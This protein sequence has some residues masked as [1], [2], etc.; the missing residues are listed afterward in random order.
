MPVNEQLAHEQWIRYTYCR[1]RAHLEFVKKADKCDQF[2]IGNQWRPEDL[3]SLELQRRPALTINK[4]LSTISTILGEQIYNRTE[5]LFRPA[6]GASAETAEALSKVWMQIS[7]NNQLPWVRSDV[8]CDGVVRSRG[9]YDVRMDFTDSVFGEVRISQLN[10]KNVVIDPDAEE[11]DP[12]NWNDVH[13]TKWMT[14]QDIGILYNEEDAEL[15]RSRM[16]TM[17]YAYDAVDYLRDSFSDTKTVS[18]SP[19]APYAQMDI[20][21][22]RNIRVID[23]Q[24]RKL[25]KC[26]HFVDVVTGDMRIVPADWD[27]DRIALFLERT[28]G[29]IAVTEKLA[30]RIRWTVTAGDVVLHDDWSPYKHFTVVPYFPHFRYGRTVGIVENL[31]SPQ[32]I[33]NKASSQELHVINTTANSGWVIE[34]NSLVNMTVEELEMNGAQTGLVVEY[35][36]GAQPPIKIQPNQVPSGLDRITYKAEEHIKTISAVSDSMQGFDRED[37][38]AKAIAYKQQRGSVNLSKLL[39]NLER[40]DWILARNVLDLVQQYYVDERILNITHDDFTRETE[41]LTI[42][43]VD[44]ATGAITNDLTIGEYDIVITS[45][46]YR[47]SLEDSQFEQAR[48]LRELGIPI[49]DSVLI[50]NSRLLRRADI[51]KQMQEQMNNPVVQ[52]QQQMQMA[53]MEAEVTLKQAQAQKT[54][55]DAQKSSADA[56]IKANEAAVGNTD[57]EKLRA[58]ME[59]ER[60]RLAMELQKM[61]MEMQLK[62]QEMEQKLQ[63]QREEHA[64][65][66][67]FEV[68]E[69]EQKLRIR[70][71]Q[72]EQQAEAQRVAAVRQESANQPSQE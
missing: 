16:G 10:S 4:I 65:K 57:V 38:A 18:V 43:A 46:P 44:P 7:Q 19:L 30:K 8:F 61:Q 67:Q 27:R 14:T 28:G 40:T 35:R 58:E 2:F 62:M 23:R 9:F 22:L 12:D 71:E 1:D 11:Y 25:D 32:E 15:L 64:M 29:Q 56:Q 24:Y 34:E 70:E 52:A 50:E 26:K 36:K 3:D 69:A 5:V 51:V 53:A 13:I 54:G 31:L 41:Q 55:A 66:Q 21:Q 60:E 37:V 59:I 20:T 48:A 45:S 42:N 17:R 68:A 49:P 39:D 72:A 33:L 63:F 6:N 47:A